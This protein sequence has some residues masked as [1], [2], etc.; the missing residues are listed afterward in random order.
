MANNSQGIKLLGYILLKPGLSR[1][2]GATI[3]FASITG[4]PFLVVINFIQPYILT[5]MLDIPTA[6]HGSISGYLAIVHEII[7]IVLTGP[8][9][10]LAD[11]IGRR[12]VMTVGFLLAAVGLM[13]YPWA[14][15]I[16]GLIFIRCIYAVGAAAMVS[17]ISVFL[18]DYPQEKSRGKLIAM[19]GVLNGAGILLLTAIGG[20]LPKWLVA[21]GFEQIPAGRLA[22]ALISVIGL[23]S[24]LIIYVGFKNGDRGTQLPNSEPILKLLVQGFG[25]A[26][27]PRIAVSYA[28]AFAARGD[29]VVIG[30]YVS[31][32]GTQAG[33]ADGLLEENALAKATIIFATIQTAALIASPIIGIMNDRINRVTALVIG[34]GLAAIGYI[35]FGLQTSPL[36]SSA[37]SIAFILGIGQ[38]SAILAGTTLIGQE[39][40][41]KITGATIGVWSFCGAVGTMIGSLLGGLLFDWWRPGAPFLLMGGL[42]LLVMIAAIYVRFRYPQEETLSI[43]ATPADNPTESNTD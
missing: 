37:M 24:S 21:A 41:P 3:L 5:A 19:A 38:I 36:G 32:W 22:M 35:L 6:Q 10:A 7:M 17:G 20:N 15:T 34:M 30:T 33:I 9:G 42:N 28:S 16:T 2:N 27:N 23:I 13:I 31:L 12:R 26:R 8:A 40:D 43:T 29:V 11:R 4:I 14:L 25:A 18:A 39:A 1:M